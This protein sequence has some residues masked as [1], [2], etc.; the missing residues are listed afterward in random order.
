MSL[1]SKSGIVSGGRS[2]KPYLASR[3]MELATAKTRSLTEPLA[4]W[5]LKNIWLEGR[6]FSFQ[7]HE[8]LRA[9]YD[10]TAGHIVLMKGAQVGGTVWGLL[11]SIHACMNG[12]NTIYYF[13]TK[14]DV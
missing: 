12:L 6:R 8:Y 5:A 1:M 14:T 7:D 13:P 2:W 10:E 4:D 11:R 3:M 9:L